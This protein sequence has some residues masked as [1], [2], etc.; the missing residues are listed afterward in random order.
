MNQTTPGVRAVSCIAREEG[1]ER[2]RPK[3]QSQR[4]GSSN[5][6]DKREGSVAIK[7]E[8]SE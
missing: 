3:W 8:S 4:R 5:D 6:P 7:G 2:S 1:G